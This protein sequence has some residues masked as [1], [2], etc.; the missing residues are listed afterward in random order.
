MSLTLVTYEGG[1]HTI[2]GYGV[3]RCIDEVVDTYLLDLTPPGSGH[4][5]T[6]E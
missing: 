5:C 3:N 4:T 6:P 1:G 2:Y